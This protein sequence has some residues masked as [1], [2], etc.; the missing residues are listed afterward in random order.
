MSSLNNL[1]YNLCSVI[2]N[3]KKGFFI[4]LQE[5]ACVLRGD[6]LFANQY[7]LDTLERKFSKDKLKAVT[8]I[9]QLCSRR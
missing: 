6:D 9:I 5:G 4:N 3:N 1:Q 2:K 8:L 7:Q